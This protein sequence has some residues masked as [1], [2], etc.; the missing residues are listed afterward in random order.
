MPTA[1]LSLSAT[2]VSAISIQLTWNQPSSLNGV[3]HDY[4]IRY[5]LSSDSSFGTPISAD[6]QLTY[7]AVGLEPFTDYELQVCQS[8]F[9]PPPFPLIGYYDLCSYLLFYFFT[10]MLNG[11]HF[12]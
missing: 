7:N 11:D 4:R 9:K 8:S 1:P 6:T 5:K 2:A 3:L 10:P 12:V